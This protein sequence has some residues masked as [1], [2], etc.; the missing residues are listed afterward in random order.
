MV[1]KKLWLL[2]LQVQHFSQH[3]VSGC[4]QGAGDT[5]SAKTLVL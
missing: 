3:N 1:E 5:E 4:I 2:N